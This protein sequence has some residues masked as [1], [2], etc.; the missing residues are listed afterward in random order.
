MRAENSNAFRMLLLAGAIVASAPAAALCPGDCNGDGVVTVDEVVRSVNVALGAAAYRLCPPTDVDGDQQV[1]VDELVRA[2]GAALHGCPDTVA[3]YRAPAQQEPA[4]PLPNGE[5][6]LPNGRR[7]Q[8]TGTQIAAETLPLNV[9]LTPDERYLLVTN[10]GYDDADGNQ[11]LQVVDTH[12]LAVTKTVVPQFFGLA[13]TP[14]AD[15]VFVGSDDDSQPDRIDAL[16]LTNGTLTREAAPLVQLPDATFPSGLAVSPDGAYLYALGMRSNTFY[17]IDLHTGSVAAASAKVGNL[18]FELVVSA[19]GRRAYVSS[20]GINNGNPTDAVPAPLPPLAAT[21]PERSSV[22]VVDVSNP[23]APQLLRYVL[24]APTLRINNTTILGGSHPTAMR[25]SPDGALL[26]VTASNLDLLIVVDTT[27]LQSIAEVPLNVFDPAAVEHQLQGLYPNALAV[28]ADGRRVY[29]ADAGINAVQVVAVDPAARTFTP[30]GF[31]PTGWYP[32]ALAL[33]ADGKRLYVANG[34]GTGIGPNGGAQ[35]D[36][37]AHQ[38]TYIAQLLKGSISVI[39]GVDTYD[40]AQGTTQVIAAN[41]LAPAEVR[42]VDGA[43]GATEVQRGN[44]VPID[45][46]S[47]P[48]DM[49]RHVVFI[50][51]E[52]RTYDQILG[53]LPG[54]NGDPTLAFYGGEVTP[55]AQAL[56]TEFSTGDNFFDDGEVS[57]PGHEWTDQANCTDFT[58]K[59]WPSNY[60]RNLPSSVLEQGEEGFSKGGFV[61]EALERQGISYRV[62]GET[63]ALLSHFASGIDGAGPGSLLLNVGNAFGH[64]PTA[65]DITALVNGDID[66]LRAAGVNIDLLQQT[67]PNFVLGFPANIIASKTDVGRAQMFQSDLEAFV[68]AGQLPSFIHI[69]LPNDHTFGASP[70]TPT[71][72]SAVAD[73][74]AALGMIVDALTHSPFWSDM[75]IFVTEDDAQDG[76]DHVAA[77][78]TVGLV[79][80]P[81]VKHGYV[82]HVHQSNVGMTK[83]ME[84][85]LGAAPMSQY[86]RLATDMRDY[87]TLEPDLTPYTARPRQ[88]PVETNPTPDRAPDVYLRRAAV[89]SAQLNFAMYD[90]AGP[91]L[92]RVLALVHTGEALE[93]Q[94]QWAVRIMLLLFCGLLSG[95]VWV[96]WRRRSLRP[97]PVQ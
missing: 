5:G 67:W 72:R 88:V 9:A 20:W 32:T 76:Q 94:A 79:L 95:G 64:F 92:S 36:A 10:D 45:F 77:H 82:S 14:A 69:W 34:K 81:F 6:V 85:L 62:Y 55:N 71:P 24:I 61:F 70:G 89:L 21:R 11:F 48:S 44:P 78:R 68:A 41:G 54:G 15:R 35:F 2:V 29:V 4:G 84:L 37:T 23:A 49:I 46:G 12:T 13:L 39:D 27:S 30:S 73:N 63:L 50:L 66:P 60:S 97:A 96:G 40:L 38:T 87:F 33:Q 26:Y 51:K 28:S 31:I 17:S 53:E 47:G 93:R 18:P 42:W 59:L 74:D 19:D 83:T 65:D 90:E 3:V 16:Q 43:P 22:A 80:S 25:L 7:V 8:P 52:N 86:D 91:E 58:E 57:T 56:A 1:T 75:A